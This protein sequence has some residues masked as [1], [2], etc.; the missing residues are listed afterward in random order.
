MEY[1]IARGFTTAHLH[2]LKNEPSRKGRPFFFGGGGASK[3]LCLRAVVKGAGLLF[4]RKKR[5]AGVEKIPS[6][7]E[8]LFVTATPRIIL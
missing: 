1:R 8:E 4:Q 2:Q 3:L 7:D 6:G 5:R